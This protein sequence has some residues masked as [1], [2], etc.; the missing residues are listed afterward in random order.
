MHNCVLLDFVSS[1]V[2]ITEHAL[3]EIYEEQQIKPFPV[4][5]LGVP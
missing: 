2:S 3:A 1:G 5:W 4:A